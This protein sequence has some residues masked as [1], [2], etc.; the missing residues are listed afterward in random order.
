[1]MLSQCPRI[2]NFWAAAFYW[3]SPFLS[4]LCNI[5]KFVPVTRAQERDRK[6]KLFNWPLNG[7]GSEATFEYSLSLLKNMECVALCPEGDTHTQSHMAHFRTGTARMLYEAAQQGI[8]L[9]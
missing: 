9:C 2:V 8:P 1:M 4:K 7:T 6:K 5:L 3:E